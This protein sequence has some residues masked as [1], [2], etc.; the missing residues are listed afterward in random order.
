MK[1]KPVRF[2]SDLKLSEMSKSGTKVGSS[3]LDQLTSISINLKPRMNMLH[4]YTFVV[5]LGA[6]QFGWAVVGNT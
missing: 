5:G 4:F 3:T 6:F 2:G 1:K